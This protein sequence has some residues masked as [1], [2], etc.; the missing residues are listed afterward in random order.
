[1]IT[2]F[3]I[4]SLKGENIIWTN[5][6]NRIDSGI[7]LTAAQPLHAYGGWGNMFFQFVENP[8]YSIW[9]SHYHIEKR[10][11]FL[12]RADVPLL[13]FTLQ[14][15]GTASYILNPFNHKT[16]KNS[17]FNILYAPY[18]ENRANFDAGQKIT[19][20]DIH[21]SFEYLQTFSSYFADLLVPFLDKVKAGRNTE[22]FYH[23]PFATNFML[24]AANNILG[25]LRKT[26]VNHYLLE[27]NVKTLISYALTCKYETDFK[28]KHVS[29]EQ[30]AQIHALKYMLSTDFSAKP[31]LNMLAKK[32]HMSL[33][34][35]KTL[36]NMEVND[37]PYHYW[38]THRMQEA[39]NRLLRTND[40]VAQIAFDL[41]FQ[42]VSNFSKAFKQF[43]G[44]APT[45]LREKENSKFKRF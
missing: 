36:F 11:S 20:L 2:P 6:T 40:P 25:I 27:L 4:T 16:V 30:I 12:A 42:N 19:T 14:M 28:Q 37:T 26:P 13:E 8:D 23:P 3:E 29:L 24:Y 41:A 7:Q 9:Y 18:M 45:E 22:L 33:P 31:N 32:M 43:Y 35:L 15:S 17:Q 1:M 44:M 5:G 21:C 10:N 34:V 39:R 38:L